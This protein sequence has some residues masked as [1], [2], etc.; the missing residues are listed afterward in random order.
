MP[1]QSRAAEDRGVGSTKLGGGQWVW[2]ENAGKAKEKMVEAGALCWRMAATHGILSGSKC[3]WGGCQ[4]MPQFRMTHLILRKKLWKTGF[5]DYLHF[6][7]SF[8]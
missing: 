8:L 3:L 2:E 1:G 6:P 5:I 7:T 4:L